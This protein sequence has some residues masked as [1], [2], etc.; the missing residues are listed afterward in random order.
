[1]SP[2]EHLVRLGERISRQHEACATG[3]AQEQD[4]FARLLLLLREGELL[5]DGEPDALRARTG[6]AGL[7]EAFLRLIGQGP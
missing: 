2:G 4:L 3:L 7:D 5:A 6:A 1:V